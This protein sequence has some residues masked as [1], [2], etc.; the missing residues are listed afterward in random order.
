MST[1]SR[2]ADWWDSKHNEAENIMQEWINNSNSDLELY[3][4]AAVASVTK[5]TMVI[6]AGFVDILRIGEGIKTG[7]TWGYVQD[8]LRLLSLAGPVARLGRL[9][10]AKWTFDPGGSICASVATAKVLKHTGTALFV[11]ATDVLKGTGG[12]APK[13]LSSFVPFLNS[14]GAAFRQVSKWNLNELKVLVQSNPKSVVLFGVKWVTPAGDHAGHALYA[15]RDTFGFFKI[16][17]RTGKIV[18]SLKDMENFYPGIGNAVA[19]GQ[20][21]IIHNSVITEGTSLISMLAMEV[22]LFLGKNGNEKQA[23]ITPLKD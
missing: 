12:I 16:A 2:V 23:I 11:K 10:F 22:N 6:G 9:G 7:G 20:A 15:F 1:L 5:A 4:K 3:S 8:G 18:S 21:I 17:D 13:D 19:Q 14:V